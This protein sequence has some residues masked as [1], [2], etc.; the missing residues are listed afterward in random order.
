MLVSHRK[1][2]D[3]DRPGDWE[4][5]WNIYSERTVRGWMR[6]NTSELR[7]H[8]FV[9]DVDLPP[10]E[11]PVRTWTFRD[12]HGQRLLTNGLRLLVGLQFLE[13]VR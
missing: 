4:R 13:M 3:R 11:D 12:E 7:F 5:G 2:G 10:R 1:Y 6:D 9:P 8:P